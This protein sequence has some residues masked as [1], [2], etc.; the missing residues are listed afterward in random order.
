[1]NNSIA[2]IQAERDKN[3]KALGI[4]TITCAAVFLFFFLVS[5]TLPQLPQ[6]IQD[7]GIEVNLGN[8]DFGHGDI[9]PLIPGEPSEAQ[10]TNINPPPSSQALAETQPE[11]APNDEPDAPVVSTSPKPEK[12]INPTANQN[13]VTKK[14]NTQPVINPT[15]VPPKPKAVYAGGKNTGSGGN[16][17]DTYNNVRNQGIAGGNGDQ[18]KPNG[19]PNSDNY[20][21]NGGT[22]SGGISISDGLS[23]RRIGGAARFVDAYRYGGTVYVNV[24]VDINGKVTNASLKQGSPFEDI[25]KIA[26]RRAYQIAFSKGAEMQTGTIKIKFENPKG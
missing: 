12:K 13:T 14:K 5:W 8:S 23:G 6:P 2:D 21:G 3:L 19:N 16:N 9:P 18:G 10:Q 1:M 11:A 15:P 17:S 25:N 7:E 4:T 22:G 24:T 20:T 26:I